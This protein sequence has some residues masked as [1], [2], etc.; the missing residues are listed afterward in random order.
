MTNHRIDRVLFF[1]SVTLVVLVCLPMGLAP[2]RSGE[3]VTIAYNWV[4]SHL[5]FLYQWFA[6]GCIVFLLWLGLGRFGDVRLG[7]ADEKPE[8]SDFS[9][10][11]MLFC[12][13]TG[14]SLL[15]WAGVEWAF[16]YSAPPH[17][18]EPRSLEAIEWGSAYGMFHWG[19]IAWCFY[20]LPTVAIAYPFYVKKVPY[21]R[22]ST[23]LSG[24]RCT[25][26]RNRLLG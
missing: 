24:H 16:Y 1:S 14:A 5:G 10:A 17:G 20:A 6:L 15:V 3:V 22:A 11:G 21:L 26:T 19:I 2:E 12:A 9:W 13:G 4:A 25:C 7:E 18:I 8:Y 23:G